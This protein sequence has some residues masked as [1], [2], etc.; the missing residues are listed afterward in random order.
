MSFD[1]SQLRNLSPEAEKFLAEFDNRDRTQPQ[2]KPVEVVAVLR[3]WICEHGHRFDLPVRKGAG[4]CPVCHTI[5]FK[6][7]AEDPKTF[8]V[9]AM[10]DRLQNPPQLEGKVYA[11]DEFFEDRSDLEP[12]SMEPDDEQEG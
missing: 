8:T 5:R 2:A 3:G 11:D 12:G 10:I 7:A 1:R 4:E 6:R 9:R